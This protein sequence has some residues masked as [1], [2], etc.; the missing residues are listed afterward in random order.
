[1]TGPG[2]W[3]ITFHAYSIINPEILALLSICMPL[4]AMCLKDAALPVKS[5]AHRLVKSRRNSGNY[6]SIVM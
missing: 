2:L 6:I 3:S 4:A 5:T 1:M